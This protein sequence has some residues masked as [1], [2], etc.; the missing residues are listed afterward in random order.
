M[1]PRRGASSLD[2]RIAVERA[3]E[4]AANGFGEPSV[5]WSEIA[6]LWAAREDV[7]DAEKVAA[8]Q[9]DTARLSRF[10]VRSSADTRAITSADRL[11][12]DGATWEIKG[13]KETRD[14]RQRF[15]EITAVTDSD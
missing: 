10:V 12:H 1:R 7:S 8:G 4:G 3:T 14:G 2:R 11:V 9:R 6:T 15:L 5:T 13:V